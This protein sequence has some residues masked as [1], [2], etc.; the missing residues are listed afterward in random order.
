MATFWLS[1]PVLFSIAGDETS[2]CCCLSSSI[3]FSA[4]VFDEYDGGWC[5]G[6]GSWLSEE[7]FSSRPLEDE[8]EGW[9]TL[10]PSDDIW[11]FSS[12]SAF[13]ALGPKDLDFFFA[14]RSS[15]I[16]RLNSGWSLRKFLLLNSITLPFCIDDDEDWDESFLLTRN[17]H[18]RILRVKEPNCECLKWTGMIV[19]M[20][21]STSWT[22]T[23]VPVSF[24]E[25][26]D[27]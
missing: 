26:M 11:I 5:T 7:G 15:F 17:P 9:W 16:N 1:S 20:K 6:I 19:D 25:I 22:I 24:H 8:E 21:A 3:S 13:L 12:P 2:D 4:F 27:E 23:A 18:R 14:C 10:T